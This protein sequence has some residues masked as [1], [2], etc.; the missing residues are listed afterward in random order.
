MS[1]TVAEIKNV[2]VLQSR[3]VRQLEADR[4]Q[5]RRDLNQS[6][7]RSNT[8][9]LA[10]KTRL[11]ALLYSAWSEAQFVQILHTP[12]ALTGVEIGQVKTKTAAEGIGAGWKRMT[13]LAFNR[14]GDE[15]ANH[16]IRSRREFVEKAIDDHIIPMSIVRNKIAHG[17]WVIA[18]NRNNERENPDITSKIAAL[19]YVKIDVGFMIHKSM[20]AIFRDLMQSPRRGH[21]KDFW[22]H[23]TELERIVNESSAWNTASKRLLLEARGQAEA[24]LKSGSTR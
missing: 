8:A 14:V 10:A 13:Q 22:M 3:N 23:H 20:A 6:L 4:V 11:Y 5:L 17:Q 9:S 18:L 21:Y 2:F 12:S 15:T 1:L 7:K 19:D 16:T 24:Q